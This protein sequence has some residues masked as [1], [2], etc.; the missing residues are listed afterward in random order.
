MKKTPD[1]RKIKRLKQKI[2]EG[3]ATAKNQIAERDK[4]I[5]IN[6]SRATKCE[7]QAQDREAE[8]RAVHRLCGERHKLDFMRLVLENLL[9]FI[10]EDEA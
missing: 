8:S 7:Y 3:I 4:A 2:Q 5:V 6:A 9:E 1:S 10:E